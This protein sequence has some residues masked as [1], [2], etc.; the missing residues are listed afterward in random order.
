MGEHHE[1]AVNRK[2]ETVSRPFIIKQHM[3]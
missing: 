3:K 1:T 2:Q